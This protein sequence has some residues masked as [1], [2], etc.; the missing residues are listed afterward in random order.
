M[1]ICL[2]QDLALLHNITVISTIHSPSLR[3][4]RLFDD[5][6]LLVAGRPAYFGPLSGGHALAHFA[7]LG[8]APDPGRAGSPRFNVVEWL[9]ELTGGG[10]AGPGA[11]KHTGL[12]GPVDFAEGY[13]ASQLRV[14]NEQQLLR[15]L[16]AAAAGGSAHLQAHVG[17]AETATSM[18][19]AFQVSL[20][21][22]IDR[23]V[24]QK[25]TQLGDRQPIPP[26]LRLSARAG[27][28]LVPH[29]AAVHRPALH[30][31]PRGREG[32][33]EGP[34]LPS[35]LRRASLSPPGP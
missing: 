26:N 9:V 18:W 8:A 13:A 25:P 16:P 3:T 27:A 7:S 33:S 10:T 22:S 12:G 29:A 28:V 6:L 5:L 11:S 15:L 34:A 2:A 24:P 30:G 1:N 20:H 31:H 32:E 35:A 21:R 14:A 4:V 19:K 23:S 17:H